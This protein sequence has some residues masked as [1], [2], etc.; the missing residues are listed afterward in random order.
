MSE[1]VERVARAICEAERMNPDDKLGG[2]RHWQDAARA[3]IE[4][5][6]EPT[7]AMRFAVW[8]D[9]YKHCGGSDKEAEMLARVK[10]AD[11]GQ[12]AQDLSSFSA[13]I[14][15]ALAQPTAEEVRG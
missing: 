5:M 13:L 12:R 2:W 1:M 8:F 6:R 3:A 11:A 9:Q 10:V 4:A 7:E 14:G 15:A